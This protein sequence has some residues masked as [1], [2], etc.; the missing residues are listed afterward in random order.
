MDKF[1]CARI[2]RM[3]DADL[4]LFQFDWDLTWTVFFLAR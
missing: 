3:R 1:V 2:V 4:R